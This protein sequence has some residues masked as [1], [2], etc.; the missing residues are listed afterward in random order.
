MTPAMA[1]KLRTYLL[2]TVFLI[3][4]AAFVAAQSSGAIPPTAVTPRELV[5]R[6]DLAVAQGDYYEAVELYTDARSA[7]PSYFEALFGL[8]R[9]YFLLEEY[10]EAFGYLERAERFARENRALQNLRGQ[11]LVSLGRPADAER[12]FR[13]VLDAEP[14][15]LEARLGLS[16]L[17][18]AR[19][20]NEAAIATLE[21]TIRLYPEN[22]RA[23]LSLVLIHDFR[24]RP[25]VSQRYLEQ[26]LRFHRS[27]PAVHVLAADHYLAQEDAESARLHAMT[28]LS[29]SSENGEALLLLAQSELALGRPNDA[30]SVAEQLIGL[31]PRAVE[32]FYLAGRAAV[33]LGDF[34]RAIRSLRR[35]LRLDPNNELIR[36][37]T[38]AIVLDAF[39]IDD[40]VR[41][42]FA[43]AHAERGAELLAS[44]RVA[45]ARIAYRRAL[46]LHPFNTNARL[47]LAEIYRRSGF[48]ARYLQELEV[49]RS[50]GPVSQMV[51]DAVEVYRSVLADSVAESWGVDQFETPRDRYR[52]SL[53][54][55]DDELSLPGFASAV[56]G[57]LEFLFLGYEMIQPVGPI[58]PVDRVSNAFEAARANDADFFVLLSIAEGRRS[59]ALEASMHLARTGSL[60][61]QFRSFTAGNDKVRDAAH[62]LSRE[63]EAAL[64]F[65][66]RLLE[67]AGDRGLISA[68]AV[69]GVAAEEVYYIVPEQSVLLAPRSF[70]LEYPDGD[71][72]GEFVVE[73]VDDLVAEG[74][75]RR[76]GLFDM[77]N[78]GDL[79][80]VAPSAVESG[81][82]RGE[83]SEQGVASPSPTVYYPPL[84]N[85][86]RELRN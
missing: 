75:I 70:A 31:E 20:R 77:V 44:N 81:E 76:G 18:L 64:P 27:D 41:R 86:V 46:L 4:F 2:A 73:V 8:A 29:L 9:A 21:D 57:Y 68:G 71:I 5:R 38:E 53:F 17:E 74:R 78:A 24:G 37:A 55:R 83:D 25:E 54:I 22:R 16:E 52:V 12:V 56:G 47:E 48:E 51:E 33:E 11:L 42:D 6:G 63:I 35:A 59:F 65:R 50:L 84:Y 30:L 23:L 72:L 10:D 26:A 69:D 14:N 1:S 66:A 49:V 28:A 43:T 39:P 13:S 67:R 7:N 80:V 60:I 19:G 61:R 85:R 36:L 15:N 32:A 34:D 79:V 3:L 62:R 45:E 58:R 82:E 40:D